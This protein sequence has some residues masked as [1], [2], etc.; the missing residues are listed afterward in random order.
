MTHLGI[1][2]KV[3]KDVK[4]YSFGLY[5]NRLKKKKYCLDIG[6]KQSITMRELTTRCS[7]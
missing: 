2:R 6:V 1:L 3:Q 4:M 7:Q 5:F